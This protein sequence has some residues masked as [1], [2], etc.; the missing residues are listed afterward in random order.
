[1]RSLPSCLV[2][3]CAVLSLVAC[4]SDDTDESAASAGGAGS[5]G[6]VTVSLDT[7]FSDDGIALS[8]TGTGATGR[9]ESRG[10]VLDASGNILVA[11][12]SDSA[13]ELDMLLLRLDDNGVLDTTFGSSGIVTHDAAAG[14]TDGKE[15]GEAIAL[16]SNGKIVVAGSGVD[17]TGGL[18]MVIWR[19]NSDGSLD[20][21]FDTDGVVAHAIGTGSDRGYGLAIDSTDRIIVVGR[22]EIASRD[23]AVWRFN[24]DGSLDTTFN[25]SGY[26][27]QDGAA[28][29]SDEERADAVAIDAAGKIVVAG[30][31]TNASNRKDLVVWRFNTD[32]TLD[33]GFDSDGMAVVVDTVST[34][35]ED[36][37][38]AML[39][40]GDGKIIVAGSSEDAGSIP[41]PT[42][43]RFN[44][45]GSLDTT[46]NGVGHVS[47]TANVGSAL[48]LVL[49]SS[50]NILASGYVDDGTSFNM[51]LW[52][53]TDAGVVD[54]TFDGDGIYTHDAAAGFSGTDGGFAIVIDASERVVIAGQSDNGTDSDVAVWRLQ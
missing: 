21:G 15:Y 30:F 4:S 40:D 3:L 1:M 26:F 24:S 52:R 32:G 38:R 34:D 22:T 5:G 18:D 14:G 8:G 41:R 13:T 46:F 23:L 28:G 11:G 9:D 10:M 44:D 29:G 54:T 51:A 20:T 39:I 49:D 42:I 16:D 35:S 47:D 2:A 50:G 7:S 6:T 53:I 27:V 33:T 19:F 25:G 43:W 48:D 12:Y 17:G 36:E 45:D 37:A 31:S